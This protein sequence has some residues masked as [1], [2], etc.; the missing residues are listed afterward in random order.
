MAPLPNAGLTFQAAKRR[1][2]TVLLRAPLTVTVIIPAHNEEATIEQTVQ[3]CLDQTYPIQQVIVIADNCTDFTAERA[4]RAGAI[5]I[6]GKCGSK[7]AAQNL[8]LPHVTS[9]VVLAIDGDATLNAPAV[10][11]MV[12]TISAGSVGTCPAAIPKDTCTIYSQYRTI[13]HAVAN[14]WT[15][16]MQDVLGRQLVLSGMANCHRT[17]VLREM[18]GFPDDTITEDFNLTWALHR[19]GYRVAFTP[20]AFV[21]T[22]EPTSLREL[23][24][25]MHRWTAGFAQTMV[26]QRGPLLDMASFIVVGSQ[27]SDAL[28]GGLAT[29]SFVPFVMSR[30]AAGLWTWWGKVWMVVFVAS[31]GVAI[32]QVG[33]RTTLKCLPGWFALQTMTGPVITWWLFRE[34]VL[35][36]HLTTWTGR[37]GCR[38]TITPMSP[39]RKVALSACAAVAGF[40]VTARGCR[41]SPR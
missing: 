19:R 39:R 27:V 41:T 38:A 10:A 18:G 21:Y 35:G 8:A 34:W 14:G 15:R 36:R 9:D 1:S 31:V 13:Y 32:H 22:Q 2:R 16:R 28:I 25:Q 6:M 23:L 20:K 37:H 12:D 11:F 4:C 7:A 26:K 40:M 33:L 24:S 29:C 5:V 30:G 17:D 3:S